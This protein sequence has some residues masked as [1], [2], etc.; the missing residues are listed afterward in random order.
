MGLSKD[1]MCDDVSYYFLSRDWLLINRATKQSNKPTHFDLS[2][3]SEVV[4]I[5]TL[6][7]AS[8]CCSLVGMILNENPFFHI[9]L[10]GKII[11]PRFTHESHRCVDANGNVL[12]PRCILHLL[13]VCILTLRFVESG[14]KLALEEKFNLSAFLVFDYIASDIAKYHYR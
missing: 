11:G 4:L 1:R 8:R 3:P 10:H 13:R 2:F 14:Y 7:A 6:R 12:R 9:H 5:F